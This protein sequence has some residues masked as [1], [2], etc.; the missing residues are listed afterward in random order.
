M[1]LNQVP[2][3]L[4][5]SNDGLQEE[6]CV[7]KVP[8]VTLRTTTERPET[9]TAGGNRISGCDPDGI[10]RC[11]D[12]MMRSDRNWKNPFGDGTASEKIIRR[13]EKHHA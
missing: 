5:V 13:I 6:A 7:L 4:R 9:V 3:R 8:C 1:R 12:K 11:A 2:Q 10:L